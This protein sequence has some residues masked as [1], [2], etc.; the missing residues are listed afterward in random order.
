MQVLLQ[1]LVSLMQYTLKGC[2]FKE[3]EYI[4]YRKKKPSVSFT[5][6]AS[7]KRINM[8]FIEGQMCVFLIKRRQIRSNK[9]I[10]ESARVRG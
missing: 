1:V 6:K 5:R 2:F 8:Q 3:N 4:E 9:I 7:S 10:V